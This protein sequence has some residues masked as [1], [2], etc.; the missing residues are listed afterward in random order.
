M[1]RRNFCTNNK[2]LKQS[3]PQ[4]T[5][6]L[7]QSNGII[8]ENNYL[9]C[10]WQQML[11]MALKKGRLIS[12]ERLAQ[13]IF[14]TYFQAFLHGKG[15]KPSREIKNLLSCIW[16]NSMACTLEESVCRG[17]MMDLVHNAQLVCLGRGR[18]HPGADVDGGNL[19]RDFSHFNTGDILCL[20][21]NL[22]I[23]FCM[24]VEMARISWM[25]LY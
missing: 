3:V 7:N 10:I 6:L 17:G 9:F 24:Y 1:V 25:L 15:E 5:S 8:N 20:R 19:L 13:R 2:S 4:R 11:V 14:N 22:T 12:P 18:I 21:C 23:N 16:G